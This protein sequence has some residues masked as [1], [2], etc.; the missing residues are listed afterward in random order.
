MLSTSPTGGGEEGEGHGFH[1]R[2]LAISASPSF[3]LFSGWNCVPTILSRPTMAVTGPPYSASATRSVRM[4]R[5]QLVRM[6][7]IGMQPAHRRWQCRRAADAACALAA[8][9]SPYAE[10][11]APDR[12][13]G[14]DRP[15]PRSSRARRSL[16]FRGRAIGHQ[17]HADADAEERLARV[18]TLFVQRLDH[19]GHAHRGRAGNRQ[20]RRHRAARSGRPARP[21]RDRWSPRS[22][23]SSACSRAARSNALAAECRLPE[24]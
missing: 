17:L 6:H 8:Y 5:R 1:F 19:A 15:R 10:F 16:P 23:R 7:E 11:S 20:R 9:S 18:A 4:G 2:K 3:W 22:R 24:P 13:D 14:C 21:A 12:T